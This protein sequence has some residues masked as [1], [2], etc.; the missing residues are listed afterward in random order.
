MCAEKH[1]L[2]K[3]MLTNEFAITNHN[4]KLT[5][6]PIKKTFRAQRIVKVM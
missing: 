3:K 6:Y 1:V 2:I 4:Q 5:D